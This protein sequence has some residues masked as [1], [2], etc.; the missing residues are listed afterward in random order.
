MATIQRSILG[1]LAGTFHPCTS[2]HA[3]NHHVVAP[4]QH[5][6]PQGLQAWIVESHL[7]C[8]P[9]PRPPRVLPPST[10]GQALRFDSGFIQRSPQRTVFLPHLNDLV[11]LADQAHSIVLNHLRIPMGASI[12]QYFNFGGTKSSLVEYLPEA[13]TNLMNLSHVNTVNLLFDSEEKFVELNWPSGSLRVFGHWK[14]WVTASWFVM[15]REILRS[16]SPPIPS[17]VRKLYISRYGHPDPAEGY[18][19]PIFQTLSSMTNL[20]TLKLSE[21]NNQPFILALDPEG[22][23]A[24][25]VLCPDLENLVLSVESWGRSHSECITRMA[26]DRAS[27]GARVSSIRI[28]FRGEPAPEEEL[29]KLAEYVARVEY[30]VDKAKLAPVRGSGGK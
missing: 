14:D 29:S 7:W 3:R 26:E 9:T 5:D 24:K 25:L 28:V 6:E 17:T 30:R 23:E 4:E 18:D 10:H 27:R 12:S 13:S 15:D 21:C 20:Q 1:S 11:V 19:C 16:L 22:S 8:D 2:I